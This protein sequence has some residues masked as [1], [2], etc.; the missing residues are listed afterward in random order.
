LSLGRAGFIPHFKISEAFLKEDRKD[1]WKDTY[2]RLSFDKD[3]TE[4]LYSGLRR[5]ETY[6]VS[7]LERI[8][9]ETAEV[10][11]VKED[12]V[13]IS[14]ILD[15]YERHEKSLNESAA[16]VKSLALLKA[17]AIS[18][19]VRLER[20]REAGKKPGFVLR[21][22]EAEIYAIAERLRGESFL[23]VRPPRWLEDYAKAA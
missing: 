10:A 18:E 13:R 1:W 23:E 22:K 9:R 21:A 6:L 4:W 16:S 2:I 7:N 8:K 14:G 15:Y 12:L 11:Q 17:A 3:M 19:I 5:L 20:E